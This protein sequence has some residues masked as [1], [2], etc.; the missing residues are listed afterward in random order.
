MAFPSHLTRKSIHKLC[1]CVR[2][3]IL[4]QWRGP[5]SRTQRYPKPLLFFFLSFFSYNSCINWSS[6]DYRWKKHNSNW[7]QQEKGTTLAHMTRFINNAAS[8]TAGYRGSN[9]SFI[10]ASIWISFVHWQIL[11]LMV[12]KLLLA[13]QTHSLETRGKRVSLL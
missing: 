3:W 7:L 5:T 6:V 10:C 11:P 2:P 12:T 8:G 13:P 9:H 4:N 1:W